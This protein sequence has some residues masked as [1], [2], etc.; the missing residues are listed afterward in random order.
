MDVAESAVPDAI[1]SR[2]AAGETVEVEVVTDMR[3]ADT[4]LSVPLQLESAKA[5]KSEPAADAGVADDDAGEGTGQAATPTGSSG[6][7][8]SL[9]ASCS[10]SQSSDHVSFQRRGSRPSLLAAAGSNPSSCS[11][12]PPQ[13][14]ERAGMRSFSTWGPLHRGPDRSELLSQHI[15][16]FRRVRRF[17]RA[18]F[19]C[20]LRLPRERLRVLVGLAVPP[21]SE[22]SNYVVNGGKGEAHGFEAYA[23]FQGARLGFVFK[24]G[25][26]GLGYYRDV[27]LAEE[28]SLVPLPPPDVLCGEEVILD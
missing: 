6:P 20:R 22:L 24:T 16:H 12:T 26:L 17:A 7:C 19:V 11:A 8:E 1:E 23:A 9:S 14:A 2:G 18:Q 13:N 21:V 3:S 27:E 10:A 15:V 4:E 25:P 28:K 5:V